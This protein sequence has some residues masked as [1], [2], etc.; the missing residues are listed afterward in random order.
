MLF[1]SLGTALSLLNFGIDELVNP[2]LR[3]SGSAKVRDFSGRKVR[4]RVGFTPVLAHSGPGRGAD[5]S[6][7]NV[8][9][10]E[11]VEANAEDG[12]R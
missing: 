7:L 10:L 5:A 9:G 2:R 12:A 11:V 8:R 6:T 4:M 1:R 3:S